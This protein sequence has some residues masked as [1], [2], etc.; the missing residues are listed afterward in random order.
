MA[1]AQKVTIYTPRA[2][3]AEVRAQA[4]RQDRSISW[5]FEQAWVIAREEIVKY[6]TARRFETH[7]AKEGKE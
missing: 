2:L 5:L 3:L 1:A 7:D 4:E 6:P